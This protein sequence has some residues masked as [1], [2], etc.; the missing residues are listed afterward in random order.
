MR[1]LCLSDVHGHLDA[2]RAVLAT[3]ERKSFHRLLIAGDIVLPGPDV[4]EAEVDPLEVWRRLRAATAT[5]V[6]GTTDK[7][8]GLLDPASIARSSEKEKKRLERFTNVRKNLGELVL[9][10][11]RGL[12]THERIMLEDGRELLL[13]HGCPM[14]PFEPMSFELDED[15]L[16]VLIGDDPADVVVCG[17]SHVPFD[18]MIGDVR[19]INV[20]SVGDAP[21]NRKDGEGPWVAHGTWIESTTGGIEVDQFVVPLRE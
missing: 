3:A 16:G 7:A 12:P 8:L 5:M 11:L 13:V 21:D 15:E 18:R 17:M 20:G 19:V 6:Q 14:D 1:F 2:L 4:P 9:R 10:E